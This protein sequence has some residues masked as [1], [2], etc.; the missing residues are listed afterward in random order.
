MFRV[1]LTRTTRDGRGIFGNF[2]QGPGALWISY[3][4]VT[5]EPHLRDL[6]RSEIKEYCRVRQHQLDKLHGQEEAPEDRVNNE[7]K[8]VYEAQLRVAAGPNPQSGSGTMAAVTE[9]MI[10]AHREK[11]RTEEADQERRKEQQRLEAQDRAARE[12]ISDDNY[13]DEAAPEYS[14]D[15]SFNGHDLR[16]AR[17]SAPSALKEMTR[18]ARH[19]LPNSSDLRAAHRPTNSSTVD[20]SNDRLERVNSIAR[21]SVA[22]A[23]AHQSRIEQRSNR[24]SSLTRESKTAAF[25]DNMKTLNR[26]WQSQESTRMRSGSSSAAGAPDDSKTFGG[27]KYERKQNGPFAG[28]LVSQGTIISIDGEDYVEYRVLTK[29]SFF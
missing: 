10:M 23:E 5:F 6:S 20:S 13:D 16:Q 12:I 27:V 15:R 18:P 1:K 11:L 9:T 25:S 17:R 7:T 29:P 21:Q 8:A 4:D 22:R 14:P 28:K 2:P 26:V 3:E 24:E 19:S